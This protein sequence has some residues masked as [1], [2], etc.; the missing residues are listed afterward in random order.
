M[1]STGGWSTKGLIRT[2]TN[3]YGPWSKINKPLLNRQPAWANR[4]NHSV[5]APSLVKVDDQHY[6]VYYAAVVAEQKT[7][8]CIGT[9]YA[10]SPTGP[11]TPNPRPLA[12][13]NGSHTGAYDSIPSEGANF[14]LIDPTPA[15]VRDQLVL[16]YKTQIQPKGKQWHTTIRMVRPLRCRSP[17]RVVAATVRPGRRPVRATHR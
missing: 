9:G 12:C 5:W 4:T 7:A 2:A 14:S 8:R 11:F 17:N 10:D 3:P 16:T 15:R 13:Y 1:A 6:V